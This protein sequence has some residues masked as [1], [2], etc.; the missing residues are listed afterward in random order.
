MADK[1]YIFNKSDD[2]ESANILIDGEISAWWGVG[3]RDFAKDIANSGAKNVML[4]INS[5]GGSVFE[6]MAISAFIKGSPT[7][8]DTSILGLCASIATPIAMA[9]KNTSIAK[10]SMFMIHNA[11]AFAGGEASDLRGTADLLDSIDKQ[12]VAIYVDTIEK[13]GKLINGSREETEAQV[14]TWQ[15]EETWFTAEESVEHGFIQKLTEGVEFLNSAN[16]KDIY[17]SCSKYKNVP[18]AFLNKVKNIADMPNTTEEQT[19]FDKFKA[20]FAT[21]EAAKENEV[22]DPVKPTEEEEK[23][24]ALA[25][26]I[27]HGL[28]EDPTKAEAKTE[29]KNEAEEELKAEV[30]KLKAEKEAAELKAQKLLEE[31]DGAPST[32]APSNESKEIKIKTSIESVTAEFKEDLDEVAKWLKYS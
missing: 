20:W 7:N 8:I 27:K 28:V 26:A 1:Q 9:G 31:K 29:V 17:N 2:N 24:T 25:L 11:S 23:A 21:E 6:G 15:N 5:G 18:T 30:A 32:Q 12:L 19:M 10:G 22:A 4:Q 14:T 16:A 13:N 3:L